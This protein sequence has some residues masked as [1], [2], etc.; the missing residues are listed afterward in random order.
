MSKLNETGSPQRPHNISAFS[1]ASSLR[2]FQSARENNFNSRFF[3]AKQDA[4]FPDVYSFELKDRYHRLGENNGQIINIAVGA[5]TEASTH[6]DLA[7]RIIRKLNEL[8]GKE[9]SPAVI[10][11]DVSMDIKNALQ[12][13]YETISHLFNIQQTI[14]E[15]LEDDRF[16]QFENL[17]ESAISLDHDNAGEDLNMSAMSDIP[18]IDAE[19]L[20]TS[21][22]DISVSDLVQALEDQD[23]IYIQGDNATALDMS[24]ISE[25]S[26]KYNNS[27][28]NNVR[29]NLTT[30]NI[31]DMPTKAF[32][33]VVIK[34]S[35]LFESSDLFGKL[36]VITSDAL[37]NYDQ[38]LSS[39]E[40]QKLRL[41]A[42][43]PKKAS[44]DDVVNT[45][46]QQARI[47]EENKLFAQYIAEQEKNSSTATKKV[48]PTEETSQGLHQ[49]PMK[50]RSRDR[51]LHSFSPM[52][53]AIGSPEFQRNS[54]A[55][56]EEA[57]NAK[58]NIVNKYSPGKKNKKKKVE[59]TSP[60]L[61]DEKTLRS[62]NKNLR[63][64]LSILGEELNDKK[65]LHLIDDI[66]AP[67]DIVKKLLEF[68]PNVNKIYGT[69]NNY[70]S[71]VGRNIAAE[72]EE[73][74]SQISVLENF[75]TN[76][77]SL[78]PQEVV[79]EKEDD[80]TEG[81]IAS[82]EGK[83]D[84]ATAHAT[85]KSPE[86]MPKKPTGGEKIKKVYVSCKLDGSKLCYKVR[87]NSR[88]DTMH[89]H[90]QK[91]HVTSY[92]ALIFA[93]INS[94]PPVARVD[95]LI[96][97]MVVRL[98]LALNDDQ[99]MTDFTRVYSF[100]EER[101]SIRDALSK[102]MPPEEVHNINELLRISNLRRAGNITCKTAEDFLHIINRTEHGSLQAAD[103]A[104]QEERDG[105][106]KGSN[107]EPS[108]RY[109]KSLNQI[110]S[111]IQF[112]RALSQK[113][114]TTQE[115]E[116]TNNVKLDN[117]NSTLQF[118][119]DSLEQ[120]YQD[121]QGRKKDGTSE[122]CEYIPEISFS[123]DGRFSVEDR[124]ALRTNFSYHVNKLFDLF[125]KS[126][127]QQLEKYDQ[128][129]HARDVLHRLIDR[130]FKVIGVVAGSFLE[131]VSEIDPEF[132]TKIAEN[133]INNIFKQSTIQEMLVEEGSPVFTEKRALVGKMDM[134][135]RQLK[136]KDKEQILSKEE[137]EE[138]IRE[139]KIYD[140]Q[141]ETKKEEAKIKLDELSP[142]LEEQK[143][144]LMSKIPTILSKRKVNIADLYVEKANNKLIIIEDLLGDDFNDIDLPL[145][146][147]N[148]KITDGASVIGKDRS[149]T[150]DQR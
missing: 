32:L 103:I 99:Q 136:P 106:L 27:K 70:K 145:P 44:A 98:N 24:A 10:G 7:G 125:H 28:Q 96:S 42:L 119:I 50:S 120:Q 2:M 15:Q 55:E 63:I 5:A 79:A 54:T 86:E 115:E 71:L 58:L 87:T 148:P 62:D 122:Y 141:L 110:A 33:D 131:E 81:K 108:I 52:S 46:D 135:K 144:Q 101:R 129:H 3:V 149:S 16:Y 102:I 66:V 130:H 14:Q 111:N 77:Q 34:E 13:Y 95:D 143:Q 83:E 137:Q 85:G 118:I 113:I 40:Q 48:P 20:N 59:A 57:M 17:D 116:P 126:L 65:L 109:I 74:E 31:Y 18:P 146:P 51:E 114:K 36:D 105:Y 91:D 82:L 12:T 29:N 92:V 133:F 23:L 8:L 11:Y 123:P 49:T 84:K 35:I 67:G 121:Q 39:Y 19:G 75:K 104:S 150:P 88:P 134:L 78:M 64:V 73:V 25:M 60:E 72:L 100:D 4:K 89:G 69:F 112:H 26:D 9:A 117:L 124:E 61:L 22:G 94:I 56:I 1:T 127:S 139:L 6:Y 43:L 37:T 132:T 107:E 80:K 21:V 53:T 38:K 128:I 140:K 45:M 41:Q 97:K 90:E 93:L 138:V 30:S 147:S 142:Q 68:E 47:L 76:L